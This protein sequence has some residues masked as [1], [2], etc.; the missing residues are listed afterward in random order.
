MRENYSD[1]QVLDFGGI[2]IAKFQEKAVGLMNVY[3]IMSMAVFMY[4]VFF[5]K[6]QRFIFS[7]LVNFGV[8]ACCQLNCV[9]QKEML[10]FQTPVLGMWHYDK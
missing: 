1:F 9:P 5:T 10:N 4:Y 8:C 7:S 6:T 3:Q 2:L